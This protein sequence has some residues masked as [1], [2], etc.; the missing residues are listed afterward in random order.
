MFP[1]R[2]SPSGYN[3]RHGREIGAHRS[4]ANRAWGDRDALRG[5]MPPEGFPS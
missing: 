2:P 4:M 1:V 3:G 5:W